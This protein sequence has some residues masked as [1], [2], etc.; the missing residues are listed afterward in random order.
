MA[1]WRC[2]ST[3]IRPGPIVAESGVISEDTRGSLGLDGGYGADGSGESIGFQEGIDGTPVLD[4]QGNIIL[5]NGDALG[6]QLS[7]DGK[8]L[9]AI[10]SGGAIGFRVVLDEVNDRYLLQTEDGERSFFTRLAVPIDGVD[11][12]TGGTEA[13]LDLGD[14][15]LDS[16]VVY[17]A[18]NGVSVLDGGLVVGT[19]Q[20][21]DGDVVRI[22]MVEG[23]SRGSSGC[24]LGQRYPCRR[25]QSDDLCR[26]GC[27]CPS[28][29]DSD[30]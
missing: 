24:L 22:D 26:W 30:G 27:Q 13:I 11:T 23:A 28:H 21:N 16:Q 1:S 5:F 18:T 19:G 15:D 4:I 14:P 17:S 8:E 2:V 3:T 25:V 6:W 9:V 7:A 12:I 29:V 10:T 20:I